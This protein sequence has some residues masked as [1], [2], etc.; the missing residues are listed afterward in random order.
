MVNKAHSKPSYYV[1]AI[2]GQNHDAGKIPLA[3][4]KQCVL[5]VID[6]P[7]AAL[8]LLPG[9]SLSLMAHEVVRLASGSID[10]L[11]NQPR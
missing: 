5:R 8:E 7:P 6:S 11:Q 4:E 1:C 10:L 9:N 2:A 3:Q